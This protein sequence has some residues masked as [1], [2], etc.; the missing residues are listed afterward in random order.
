MPLGEPPGPP[1]APNSRVAAR[2]LAISVF[3]ATAKGPYGSSIA[4]DVTRYTRTGRAFL[5]RNPRRFRADPRAPGGAP[6][7]IGPAQ[8]WATRRA[9][10]R[11]AQGTLPGAAPD[12]ALRI[13]A[14]GMDSAVSRSGAAT[15][16]D[17]TKRSELDQLD[18]RAVMVA[19][20]AEDGGQARGCGNS[21]AP[22]G[23]ARVAPAGGLEGAKIAVRTRGQDRF[24]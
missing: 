6:L 20:G 9:M 15:L 14:A 7:D 17:P 19:F 13:G 1:Q 3:I 10:M 11:R 2:T 12:G 18:P 5:L 24:A 22:S 23:R 4:V 21:S 8:R 16:G